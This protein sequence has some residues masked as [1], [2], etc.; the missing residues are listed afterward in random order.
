M[1]KMK[2]IIKKLF[3]M[4]LMPV[5]FIS[6]PS[7]ALVFYVL[8]KGEVSP[9]IA[10]FSYILSAYA[11]VITLI[12]TVEIVKRIRGG[13][14]TH[15][16]ARRI[17]G[18]PLV[19]RYFSEKDFR[20]EVSL[21][22]S[23]AINLFYAG[24]KFIS[25]FLYHSVWFGTLAAYY[26]LLA[27]MRFS[28]LRH[29]RKKG[30]KTGNRIAELKI[31][32]L[33]GMIL[34]VLDWALAGIIILVVRKNSGFEYPGMLI[35]AMAFYTFYAVITAVANVVKFRKHKNPALSVIKVINLT[36]ALVSLLSLETAMLTQFGAADD[37]SFRQTMSA[38]TGA[39]VSLLV[40]AMAVYIIGRTTNQIK[41]EEEWHD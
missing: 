28:L 9:M 11:M 33:C 14:G 30:K 24:I 6:I 31:C 25:G 35:Y 34:L 15:P 10:Y 13:I 3:F 23:F 4:P 1:E 8:A 2:K 18:I 36:A 38:A 32:R 37:A 27:V 39:G 5:L 12:K 40:L 19:E 22:P 41:K 20:V 16:F 21:Y 17:L 26:I 29:V 7:F